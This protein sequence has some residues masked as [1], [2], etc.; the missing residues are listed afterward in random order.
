MSLNHSWEMTLLYDGEC[1]LCLREVR[2]LEAQDRGR[3]LV[4]FVD[5][6]DPTY[7]PTQHGGVTFEAAMGRIHALKADGT[8]LQGVEVFR[9]LYSVLGIGW[10]YAAT[11]WP[12]IRP[13]VD[14]LYDRWADWRLALTGRPSLAEIA[15]QRGNKVCSSDRCQPSLSK[16]A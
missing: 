16:S 2:F 13:L 12:V 3:G 8:V 9:Q 15:Q 14:A 1:P 7:D 4:Q 5:V 6:M 11:R 10:I